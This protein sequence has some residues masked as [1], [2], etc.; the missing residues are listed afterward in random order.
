MLV[1]VGKVGI[2]VVDWVMC[3]EGLLVLI[4]EGEDG[5]IVWLLVGFEYIYWVL[6]FV[7][8]EFKCVILDSYI[9]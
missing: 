1:Y 8:G 7:F 4:W 6:L 9:K 3:G 2:E 5:V